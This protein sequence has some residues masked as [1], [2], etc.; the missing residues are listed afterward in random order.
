MI[1]YDKYKHSEIEWL[2]DVPSHWLTYRIDSIGK[3]VRG[4]T[5]FKKDELLEKGDYVA[6][7]YG[8]TY[9]VDEV[10]D[11]FEY[12]VNSEFYKKSQVVSHGDTILISTSET[13][14]D[15]GHSCFYNRDEAGLIGGEQIL[16]KPN[17]QLVFEKYLYYYSKTFCPQLRK[18]ATGLKVFRFN[19][20]NLKQ[21]SISIPIVEEQK[22][23]AQYLDTKTQAI[24][25]KVGLLQ[26]KTDYY[27]ELRKSIINEAV[28]KGL[29]KNVQ[30]KDSGIDWIGQIPK[31]WNITRVKDLFKISRGR[32][33]A[34]TELL[35]D[36][37]FPV[38][39]SQ[40]ENRGILGYINT[41]DFDTDLITWTT[42]GVNAGTVFRRASKFSC[43]NIC[44]TLIPK[45]IN[46]TSLDYFGYAI[47][48]ST[49]H[50]KRI[51]TNGAKIMSNEMAVI[52]I[53]EPPTKEEQTKIA[54]YLDK[55]TNTIDAIVNNIAKQID[56]IKELRKTLIND[57][58]T[59]KIKVFNGSLT[60][61]NDE[62]K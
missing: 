10:N 58:V 3:P 36:G 54:E 43:T 61:S 27:T 42:D 18:Y 13:I 30:L 48:E 38:Y 4:N 33:I 5:S 21:I 23:I 16:F 35:D 47:A 2:G 29:D 26:Q 34:K 31:H 28:T 6:L 8:K 52:H 37:K 19:I 46:K 59:G 17:R 53:I 20:D 56:H 40:T 25:K 32:V 14:E 41:Y 12:F 49:Q 57:V 60:D 45:N 62:L 55:K 9:K 7:Q 22:A 39:S 15:L 24:N 50:N 1:E 11:L 51:D 44:G